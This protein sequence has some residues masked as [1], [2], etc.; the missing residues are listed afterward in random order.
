MNQQ[1]IKTHAQHLKYVSFKVHEE[2]SACHGCPLCTIKTLALISTARSSFMDLSQSHFVSALTVVFINSK[3]LSSIKIASSSLSSSTFRCYIMKYQDYQELLTHYNLIY[4][5]LLLALSSEKHV[6]LE[7][8]H[9][10]IVSENPGQTQFHTIKRSSCEALIRHSPKLNINWPRLVEL[11]VC[12][13]GLQ[14]LDEELIHIAERCKS[15][16]AI[17][18]GECKEFVKMCGGRLTQ[19]SIMEEVLMP[20]ST[21]NMEPIHSEV[22]KQLGRIWFPCMMPVW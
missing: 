8:L 10:D 3:S 5:E 17:G 18:L 9:I 22:S 21:Y 6:H 1:F 11:V 14:P 7:H 19:L 16:T 4:D 15:L 13:N 12:A 2:K 20:D